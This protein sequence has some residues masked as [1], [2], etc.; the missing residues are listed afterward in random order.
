M[1][2]SVAGG[3]VEDSDAEAVVNALSDSA[4]AK[5]L[6]VA[7]AHVVDHEPELGRAL[8]DDVLPSVGRR[9]IGELLRD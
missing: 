1:A 9:P 4:V 8:R 3:S 2:V 5:A 7:L 6:A